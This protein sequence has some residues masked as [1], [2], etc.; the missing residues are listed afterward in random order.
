MYSYDRRTAAT[1]QQVAETVRHELGKAVDYAKTFIR[2]AEQVMHGLSE[3]PPSTPWAIAKALDELEESTNKIQDRI[4][5][6]KR[7]EKSITK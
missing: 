6:A 1:E 2:E 7:S 3:G 5:A 4:D